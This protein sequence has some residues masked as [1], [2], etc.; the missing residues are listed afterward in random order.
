[1]DV[2][3]ST[4]HILVPAKN[5]YTAKGPGDPTE[6]VLPEWQ[7]FPSSKGLGSWLNDNA[8]GDIRQLPE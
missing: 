1:M 8:K 5:K 6:Y 7:P 3:T 2:L 4:N